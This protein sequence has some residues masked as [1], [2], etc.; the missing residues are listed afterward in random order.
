MV[1]GAARNWAG[2]LGNH[3][4][5]VEMDKMWGIRN[6][7]STKFGCIKILRNKCS[8]VFN[9]AD[10][11]WAKSLYCANTKSKYCPLFIFQREGPVRWEQWWEK[12]M[13]FQI[14]SRI[15]AYN[16]KLVHYGWQRAN[17][18]ALRFLLMLHWQ[19]YCT[20]IKT[21]A[22]VVALSHLPNFL[23]L[24]QTYF[25][26]GLVEHWIVLLLVT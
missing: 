23:R 26:V 14:S 22:E 10:C 19:V 16:I 13:L 21:A 11:R 6:G 7:G 20:S 15:V 5:E 9:R 12:A 3:E 1:G 2:Q 8:V 17:W 25:N 18:D 4:M 24:E